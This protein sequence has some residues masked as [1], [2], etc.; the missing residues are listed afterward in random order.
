MTMAEQP[1]NKFRDELS[2]EKQPA[3]KRATAREA[4][5]ATPDPALERGERPENAHTIAQS[6]SSKG[7]PPQQQQGQR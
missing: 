2:E 6:G 7:K 3:V 5:R 1:D 4:E